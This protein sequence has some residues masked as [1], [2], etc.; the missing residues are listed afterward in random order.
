MLAQRT[1]QLIRVAGECGQ[2]DLKAI[3]QRALAKELGCQ[4]VLL[5]F[6]VAE[7]LIMRRMELLLK[8]R[9]IEK[10]FGLRTD[11]RDLVTRPSRSVD[12]VPR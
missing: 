6:S 11:S 12:R 8:A 10:S 5:S 2:P 1:R 4:G 9:S 7:V 3:F